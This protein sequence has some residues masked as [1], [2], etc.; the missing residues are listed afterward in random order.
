MKKTV[1]L[2]STFADLEPYREAVYRALRKARY[3]V[4]AMEDYVARDEGMVEACLEDVAGR[5]LYIGLVARRYG[6]VPEDD[7]PEGLSITHLEYLK[8]QKEE[9]AVLVFLLEDEREWDAEFT[10]SETGENDAGARIAAFRA[11]LEK[12]ASSR[13]REPNELAVN[14]LA[15]VMIAESEA[16]RGTLPEEI[17]SAESL[18][19]MS[20][21]IPEIIGKISQAIM[22]S[23]RPAD[24]PEVFEIDLGDGDRWWS[25]RLHLLAGLCQEFT[26]VRL[27]VFKG[28]GGHYLGMCSPSDV[29]R[30]V[31]RT[32]RVAEEAYRE[33]LPEP[34]NEAPD[35]LDDVNGVVTRFSESMDRF[36][37]E[38]QVKKWIPAR[39]VERWRGFDSSRLEVPDT[40]VS[41]Q[42][43]Q[44]IT[45]RKT[46]YVALVVNE[47]LHMVV[48]RANL[49]TKV[50]KSKYHDIE[51]P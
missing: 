22:P 34:G 44:E 50:A 26:Q 21:Q 3:D 49:A 37:G 16:R 8:A 47:Q 17:G 24:K 28:L 5:D 12:L 6:H 9:M 30:G 38:E 48:N 33:S 14:V 25:T 19:M 43:L 18:T 13:F 41:P 31:A 2:S 51:E 45:D 23:E 32:T 7:N 20:S 39:V 27:F 4:R 42:L 29:R 46:P 11:E 15:S 35:P 1:Y 10:D 40:S 36:G